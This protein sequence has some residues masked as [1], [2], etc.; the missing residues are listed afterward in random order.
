MSLIPSFDDAPSPYGPSGSGLSGPAMGSAVPS[1]NYAFLDR[2][3]APAYDPSPRSGV[4][5]TPGCCRRPP[6]AP[7]PFDYRACRCSTSARWTSSTAPR[8]ARRPPASPAFAPFDP[9]AIKRDFPILQQNVNGRPLVWLDNAATTQKP[10]A[11]IDRLSYF[12]EHENSNIHRAAHALAARSTDA[13]E[14]A[15]DKVRALPQGAD[16]RRDHLRARR[17]RRHQPRRQ[18][19]GGRNVSEGDEIVITHLEHHANIVPWQQLAAEKGAEAAGRSGRRQRPDDARGVSRSCS[20]PK[21]RSS[22]SRQV[23]NALGTVTPVARDGRDGAPRTAPSRSSTA[24]KAVSHMPVDVQA[25]DADFFVFSGHK[26][27]A[28]TGIGVV[29]GK[30]ERARSDAAVAGRR[31]HDPGRHL[32]E[33]DVPR[34]AGALRGRHR[35]HRRR[36]RPRRGDRLPR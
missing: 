24:R 22:R 9:Y 28:P 6:A 15:R 26:M 36:G 11:V 4:G 12:Y 20:T 25:L 16:R 5:A 1:D 27:F 19:W 32:R 7:L 18:G 3:A 8:W 17:D 30:P 35:Q 2:G 34:S 29:Y 13:Y 14:A 21:T 23:S 33:D 10:Q 31:Q